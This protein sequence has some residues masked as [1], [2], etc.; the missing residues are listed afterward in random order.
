MLHFTITYNGQTVEIEHSGGPFEFGRGPKREN[1]ARHTVN[2]SYVSGNHVLVEEVEYSKVRILN[3]SQRNSIRLDNNGAINIGASIQVSLP[4]TFFIGET[5][6]K[7]EFIADEDER[8]S[9][10]E[11]EALLDSMESA[12]TLNPGQSSGSLLDLGEA[13]SPE[14]LAVWFETLIAVQKS[15]GGSLEFFQDTAKAVVNLIGLDRGLV[16]MIKNGRWMV[17]ARFPDEDVENREFSMSVL[18][19]IAKGRKTFYQSG[20]NLQNESESV[21]GI[22]AVIASPIFDKSENVVGAIY[23]VRNKVTAIKGAKIGVNPL[24]AQIVQLLSSSVSAGLA[25]QEQEAEAGRLRVQF[26]QF[27][28]A[29]LARELQKN[30]KLLE[31]HDTEITVLFTDIRG[32]SRISESLNP[33]ETCSLVADVME[34]LTS[35]VMA[36]E[37]VV[38]N[39]SGD[40]IMAMWNAPAPQSDHAIKACKAALAMVARMPAVQERW[41]NKVSLPVK[42]GIGINTGMALCG[43]TGSKMKFQYGA[44]GH[45]VNLASRIEGATK[46]M[47]VPILISGF[48]KKLV[49]S[50]FAT[51]KL[52]KIRVIGINEPVDI[53]HLHAEVSSIEWRSDADIYES[54]LKHYEAR[55]FGPACRDL[56]PLIANHNENYDT[57]SLSLMAKSIEYLRKPPLPSFNGVE[58]LESK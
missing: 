11:S 32:F 34:E 55:E 28:S 57:A 17:Q 47:G 24:E 5:F 39:Y 30:H 16:L 9:D 19:K 1:I 12:I 46:V 4:V 45:T 33:R 23:G 27:F 38:V 7:I 15:A 6:I 41:K 51:R 14:K 56:Y 49:G 52:R 10:G 21:M 35:C 44:L 3:L 58:D 53:Y 2:D 20:A 25:R 31:G 43:N 26:E 50:A 40:G 29:D 54:A 42:V 22:E 18:G 36:F 13:P 48:T 37:G 8:E